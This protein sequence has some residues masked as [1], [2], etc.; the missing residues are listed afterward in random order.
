MKKFCANVAPGMPPPPPLPSIDAKETCDAFEGPGSTPPSFG[1]NFAESLEPPRAAEERR[2]CTDILRKKRT[3]AHVVDT[4]RVLILTLRITPARRWS[5]D[6]R[7]AANAGLL[8]AFFPAQ[9]LHYI[10]IG[11][12]FVRF[13]VLGVFEKNLKGKMIT[14]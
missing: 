8:L 10:L 2:F 1:L 9:R 6:A 11:A 13:V 12:R 7:G 4:Q 5:I 14:F 3:C